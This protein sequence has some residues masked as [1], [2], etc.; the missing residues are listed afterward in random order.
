MKKTDQFSDK[1]A[2]DYDFFPTISSIHHEDYNELVTKMRHHMICGEDLSTAL[3]KKINYTSALENPFR[4]MIMTDMNTLILEKAGTTL[5]IESL[6]ESTLDEHFTKIIDS[7]NAIHGQ[8]ASIFLDVYTTIKPQI[9]L[10]RVSAINEIEH[11]KQRA[12]ENHLHHQKNKFATTFFVQCGTYFHFH[13]YMFAQFLLD[14]HVCSTNKFF[15]KK[16]VEILENHIEE[17]KDECTRLLALY[18]YGKHDEANT[19]EKFKEN[20]DCQQFITAENGL[21]TKLEKFMLTLF[22]FS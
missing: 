14:K 17:N 6:L 12:L 7:I 5:Y 9:F 13:E 22:A 10:D 16:Q 15:T 20:K 1:D 18:F 11:D 3:L 8:I 4:Y 19:S 2:Y 21:F